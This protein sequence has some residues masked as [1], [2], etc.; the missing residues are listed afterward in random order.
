M[1]PRLEQTD[2]A[3][4]LPLSSL[5]SATEPAITNVSTNA[6]TVKAADVVYGAVGPT[7]ENKKPAT[8]GPVA[9][10][11]ASKDELVD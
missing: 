2:Y 11:R 5:G 8:N 9:R 6:T 7:L 10:A 4:L 3:A 1:R